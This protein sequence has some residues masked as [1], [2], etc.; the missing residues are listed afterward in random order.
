MEPQTAKYHNDFTKIEAILAKEF[1]LLRHDRMPLEW[2]AVVTWGE[3]N[4]A[5]EFESCN[6]DTF[7]NSYQMVLTTNRLSTYVIV[8]YNHIGWIQRNSWAGVRVW[9]SIEKKQLM[10]N[11]DSSNSVCDMDKVQ[12]KIVLSVGHNFGHTFK[13]VTLCSSTIKTPSYPPPQWTNLPTCYQK[14]VVT[15]EQAECRCEND[16][17]LS[18]YITYLI[19]IEG[20]WRGRMFHCQLTDRGTLFYVNL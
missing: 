13:P 11:I 5:G 16:P 9:D 20:H 8:S 12:K 6:K 10:Y 4:P 7:S 3:V 15:G 18:G 1:P 19:C 2:A 17:A 14:G